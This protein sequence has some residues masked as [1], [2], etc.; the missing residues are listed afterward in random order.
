M[1]L[2]QIVN[3]FRICRIYTFLTFLKMV[4][5]ERNVYFGGMAFNSKMSAL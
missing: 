1:P 2:E 4:Y 5:N 3:L